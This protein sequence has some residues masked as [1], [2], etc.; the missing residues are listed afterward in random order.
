MRSEDA[1]AGL[2]ADR[3]GD[4][5]T[6]GVRLGGYGP[7]GRPRLHYPDLLLVTPDGRRVAVELELSSKG[8]T[9]REK[10]LRG[11]AADRDIDAVVYLVDNPAVGR[12]IRTSAARVGSSGRIQVQPVRWAGSHSPRDGGAAIARAATRT[13]AALVR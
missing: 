3:V 2:G 8:R 6:F 13:Q 4:P 11:Y 9:R 5:K 10:I 7:G 12:A 1:I